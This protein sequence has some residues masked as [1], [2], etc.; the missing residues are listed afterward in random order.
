M[1]QNNQNSQGQGVFGDFG[2]TWWQRMKRPIFSRL[3]F[4]EQTDRPK[5]KDGNKCTNREK[6]NRNH[7]SWSDISRRMHNEELPNC[8]GADASVIKSSTG[9]G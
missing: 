9:Y 8:L 2:G 7:D 5:N 1:I 3:T 4:E 6:M